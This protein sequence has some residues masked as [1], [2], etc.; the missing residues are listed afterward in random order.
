MNCFALEISGDGSGGLV[1]ESIG[2][3]E[4]VEV[5]GTAVVEV[6]EAEEGAGVEI[7]DMVFLYWLISISLREILGSA[8]ERTSQMASRPIRIVCYFGWSIVRFICEN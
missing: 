6:V 3:V 2:G 8:C 4:I 5:P 1:F 7:G